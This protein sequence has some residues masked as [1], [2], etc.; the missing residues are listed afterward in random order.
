MINEVGLGSLVRVI[1]TGKIGIV[2]RDHCNGMLSVGYNGGFQDG[3]FYREELEFFHGDQPEIPKIWKCPGCGWHNF[4][5]EGRCTGCEA[6]KKG[7]AR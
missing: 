2:R 6:I 3:I 4:G 1:R 5:H 7:G